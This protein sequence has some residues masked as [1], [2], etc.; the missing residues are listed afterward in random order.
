MD[1]HAWMLRTDQ[2][3]CTLLIEFR[4]TTLAILIASLFPT[5]WHQNTFRIPDYTLE[6]SSYNY[7]MFS[8]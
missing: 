4:K 1:G 6:C 5:V 8:L 7:V 3:I 2:V